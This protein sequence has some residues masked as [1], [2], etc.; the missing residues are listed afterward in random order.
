MEVD[1]F[2]ENELGNYSIELLIKAVN[3]TYGSSLLRYTGTNTQ[4]P[5]QFITCQKGDG[6]N[7]FFDLHGVPGDRWLL[8]DFLKNAPYMI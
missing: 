6:M 1:E 2:E 5:S 4:I 8:K 7:H 3:A